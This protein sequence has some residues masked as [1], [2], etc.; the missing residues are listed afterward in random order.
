[1]TS[2]RSDKLNELFAE[3]ESENNSEMLFALLVDNFDYRTKI[4]AS[5]KLLPF[6]TEEARQVLEALTLKRG[7]LPF[8]AKQILK[9]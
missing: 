9:H 5:A 4:D 3:I 2:I 7:I 1:M 6:Y 8:A